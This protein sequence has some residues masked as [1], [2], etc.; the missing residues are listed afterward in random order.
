MCGSNLACPSSFIDNWTQ[1]VG[2]WSMLLFE[3]WRIQLFHVWA[4]QCLLSLSLLWSKAVTAFWFLTCLCSYMSVPLSVSNKLIPQ[5]KTQQRESLWL[6]KWSGLHYNMQR[7]CYQKISKI[8]Y[9][10]M[11]RCWLV[12]FSLMY[13]WFIWLISF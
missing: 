1:T 6:V 7:K 13:F 12:L 9:L 10:A 8:S 2:P 11:T 5:N 3:Q 4:H